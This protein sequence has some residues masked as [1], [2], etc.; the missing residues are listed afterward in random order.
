MK[1][2][3]K[4]A[5]P[6][7]AAIAATLFIPGMFGDGR[8]IDRLV[9]RKPA[10][11]TLAIYVCE[12]IIRGNLKS[13]SSYRRIKVSAYEPGPETK[14]LGGIAF[15]FDAANLYGT[16][17]RG[18]AYCEYG[19][20]PGRFGVPHM[21]LVMI[22]GRRFS[23]A[24]ADDDGFTAELHVAERYDIRHRPGISDTDESYYRA[25]ESAARVLCA[26]AKDRAKNKDMCRG[27]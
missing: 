4:V 23:K 16:P 25:T 21:T 9:D 8:L 5:V 6:L 22:G 2:L 17:L 13:P 1:K 10:M 27:R 19:P 20:K 26:T 15:S 18:S 11:G 3:M 24:E 7:V 12:E 14:D